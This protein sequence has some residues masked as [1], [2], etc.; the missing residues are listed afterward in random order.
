MEGK[1]DVESSTK[2]NQY[3]IPSSDDEE[4]K[5]GTTNHDPK[6]GE[7]GTTVTS[8][9][10]SQP[11]A[12]SVTDP[13]EPQS[14]SADVKREADADA[15]KNDNGDSNSGVV[16]PNGSLTGSGS[17]CSSPIP[18]APWK[19]RYS[20]RILPDSV[21]R[22]GETVLY[23]L[24]STRLSYPETSQ[25]GSS[26]KGTPRNVASSHHSVTYQVRRQ[27][28]DFEL[29]EHCL[30]TAAFPC[31]GLILPPLPPKP[32]SNPSQVEMSYD[33]LKSSK[34]LGG[35]KKTLLI[36]DEWHKDCWHL[37]EWLRLMLIHPTF[38]KNIDVWERFLTAEKAA[39]RV[40]IKKSNTSGIISK[41]SDYSGFGP[42]HYRNVYQ[43][44]RDCD[45]FFQREKDWVFMYHNMTRDTLDSFN[46]R[47]LARISEYIM[48]N[49]LIYQY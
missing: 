2:I 3:V 41:I 40:R 37:Q 19:Q 22:D 23:T 7:G 36:C 17:S 44:H 25:L 24:E 31:D 38:G 21:T 10:S 14:S 8:S 39:P 42:D 15:P 5:P 11:V 43:H 34:K 45:E 6:E 35:T 33:E 28:E 29:L 46:A 26:G 20:V 1:D 47:I 16:D 49:F 9:E 13:Q 18:M 27:Y 30:S 32:S 48:S 4:T 12:I